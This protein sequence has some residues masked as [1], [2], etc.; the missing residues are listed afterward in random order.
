MAE[1]S[2]SL[3]LLT[4][5]GL[6]L[7]GGIAGFMAGLLG[8]GGGIIIVPAIYYVLSHSG[9]AGPHS[10]HVAVATSLAVIMFTAFSSGLAH[11][12]KGAMDITLVRAWGPSII[13]GVFAGT[14]LSAFLS[15]DFLAWMFAGFILVMAVHMTLARGKKTR[16]KHPP[17]ILRHTMGAVIGMVSSLLGIGGAT[18]SVPAMTLFNIPI[19]RAVGTAPIFGLI[20]AVPATLGFILSG[21]HAENLPPWCFGYVNLAGIILMAP[22]AIVMVPYGAR[23]THALPTQKLRLIFA[24]FLAVVAVHMMYNLFGR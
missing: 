20:I 11:S 13:A 14:I 19:H 8:V 23:L 5:A 12:K 2:L 9:Y 1:F 3:L 18:L 7:A 16:F 17:A 24:L 6:G 22:G 4:A 10:M 15:S 21:L